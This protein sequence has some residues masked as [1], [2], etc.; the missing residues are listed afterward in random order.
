MA[1]LKERATALIEKVRAARPFVDHLVRMVQH[2]GAMKA[3]QQAGAITYFGF[4]SFFPILALA[5]FVVGY[6]AK[7]YPGAEADLVRGIQ[8]VLPGLVG[9]GPDEISLQ[10]IQSAAGA[11]GLIGVAGVLY[12]GLGWLSSLRD[13]L[14]IVFEEPVGEQP[15][16]VFGKLRD[17]LTLALV[18]LTLVVSVGVSGLVTTFSTKLLDLVNLDET[19][20]PLV[21][22][23]AILLGLAAS[24]VL[25]FAIFLLL[26]RPNVPRLSLW[27]GALFGAIGFE[28]LKQL[29]RVL[30]A[31]TKGQP[32]FQAFGIALIL[33]VWINYF[34]RVVLYAAAFAHTSRAARA[35]RED[36]SGNEVATPASVVASALAASA[37]PRAA[38]RTGEPDRAP[39]T[40]AFVEQIDAADPDDVGSASAQAARRAHA[41]QQAAH[42]NRLVALG[43][44]GA[45]AALAAVTIQRRRSR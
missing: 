9:N 34:S 36:E 14:T 27:Q 21:T 17:L 33:V 23:L 3:S 38:D 2:Y 44:T 22:L 7:V 19:L 35:M 41:E 31:S 39:W 12:S 29:S 18:G 26:A 43:A 24:A 32:A 10:R 5:F 11:V 28:V 4:L 25:F 6:V 1:S 37:A 16:F 15:N 20:A 40:A 45:A 42:R 13:A 30:L 8:Q